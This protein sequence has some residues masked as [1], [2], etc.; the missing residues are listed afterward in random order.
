MVQRLED[1]IG[2]RRT[3]L[4]ATLIWGRLEDTIGGIMPPIEGLTLELAAVYVSQF[5][6]GVSAHTLGRFVKLRRAWVDGREV[7]VVSEV[8]Q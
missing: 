2:V 4:A 7:R 1:A 5:W 3:T 8:R 6:P